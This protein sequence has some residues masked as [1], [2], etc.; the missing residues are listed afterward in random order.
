MSQAIKVI[1]VL[2]LI[3]GCVLTLPQAT[4]TQYRVREPQLANLHKLIV[5]YWIVPF[6][7]PDHDTKVLEANIR[8]RVEALLSEA[9]FEIL[10][11][12][13]DY[14]K[15]PALK[16]DISSAWGQ[17]CLDKFAVHAKARLIDYV[18]LRRPGVGKVRVQ[19]EIWR[20]ERNGDTFLLS[21]Q[22]ASAT[23]EQWAHDATVAFIEAVAIAANPEFE[24]RV[25]E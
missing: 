4:T 20:H 5:E 2:F 24:P 3:L 10:P 8:A 12:F 21:R 25:H 9:G 6:G 18:Y 13:S 17:T 15:A 1:S 11:Q 22:D 19:A 16:F 23:L 14:E 7:I